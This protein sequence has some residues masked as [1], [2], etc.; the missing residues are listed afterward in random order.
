MIRITWILDLNLK[1][2]LQLDNKLMRWWSDW[3]NDKNKE[4]KKQIV[5]KWII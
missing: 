2:E 1:E 3:M 5:R 4:C